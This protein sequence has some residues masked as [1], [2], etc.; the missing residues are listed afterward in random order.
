[1][2]ENDESFNLLLALASRIA[3]ASVGV[4]KSSVITV[5]EL[6]ERGT[7]TRIDLGNLAG[8]DIDLAKVSFLGEASN[9]IVL[10]TKSGQ[11]IIVSLSVADG[12]R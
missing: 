12:N 5:G 7:L 1:M 9:S 4:S 6:L 8:V 3:S 2:M 11:R 10:H